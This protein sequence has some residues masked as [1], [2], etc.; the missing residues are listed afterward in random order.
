[1]ITNAII[2]TLDAQLVAKSEAAKS[3]VAEFDDD[4]DDLIAAFFATKADEQQIQKKKDKKANQSD[5]AKQAKLRDKIIDYIHI[6][7]CRR[8]FFLAWYDDLTYAD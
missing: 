7:Q 1:M 4:Q 3:E 5:A 8:L 6:A 2:D